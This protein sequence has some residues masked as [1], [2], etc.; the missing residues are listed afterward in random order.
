M[1]SSSS[2]SPE[3]QKL[4]DRLDVLKLKEKEL[5]EKGDMSLLGKLDDEISRIV[6]TLEEQHDVN[7]LELPCMQDVLDAVMEPVGMPSDE[8]Q[9][10]FSQNRK[11]P[12]PS[13]APM[14]IDYDDLGD[15]EEE[16]EADDVHVLGD[17]SF[18]P[19][20]PKDK[21][22]RVVKFY[23]DSGKQDM[24]RP[25][26]DGGKRVPVLQ[27]HQKDAI[28]HCRARFQNKQGSLVCHSMGLGKT[29]TALELLDDIAKGSESKLQTF[30]I[31]P[32]SLLKTWTNEFSKWHFPHVTMLEPCV[33]TASVATTV[34]TMQQ[35]DTKNMCIVPMTFDIFAATANDSC[36]ADIDID[37]MLIDEVHHLK[38][39]ATQKTSAVS[40][41]QEDRMY[42]G[43]KCIVIGLTGTPV[44]NSPL[45]MFTMINIVQPRAFGMIEQFKKLLSDPSKK[46]EDEKQLALHYN[47]IYTKASEIMHRQDASILEAQLPSK[48]EFTITFDGNLGESDSDPIMNPIQLQCKILNET[49][50][51]RVNLVLGLIHICKEQGHPVLVFSQRV[52]FL[53]DCKAEIDGLYLHGLNSNKAQDLVSQFQDSMAGHMVFYISTLVGCGITLTRAT[54]VIIADPSWNP[55]DDLQAL[56]RAYRFGQT[57]PVVVYRFV[58]GKSIEVRIKRQQAFKM[59]AAG[60]IIDDSRSL[61][62]FSNQERNEHDPDAQGTKESA[63][64]ITQCNDPV[65]AT[66]WR[67]NAKDIFHVVDSTKLIEC[68]AP[69]LRSDIFKAQQD[70]TRSLFYEANFHS[71]QQLTF[72]SPSQV[73]FPPIILSGVKHGTII[74]AFVQTRPYI[75]ACLQFRFCFGTEEEMKDPFDDSNRVW[76]PAVLPKTTL[77]DRTL[78]P[79]DVEGHDTADICII[80]QCRP[81]ASY[82]KDCAADNIPC[83]SSSSAVFKLKYLK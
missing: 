59:A 80:V 56:H 17:D 22:A 20:L 11:T 47:Y 51:E 71:T 60:Q 9:A 8:A 61:S 49:I 41:L 74:S 82:W 57:N 1:A 76:A 27:K 81:R 40:Q 62:L 45:D 50:H 15:S 24:T 23:S 55:M 31:C 12:R 30:L 73:C 66:F 67:D 7:V 37:L 39:G 70:Y 83:W 26:V 16:M 21:K 44:Q 25:Q 18:I 36:M 54:R 19:V 77:Q 52:K 43:R 46:L 64:D 2:F 69:L 32:K 5:E 75:P 42:F 6:E 53:E 4:V 78:I 35:M 68:G 34:S 14:P 58:C 13:C 3:T 10:Y 63:L 28:E 33:Q 48:H 38:N 79:I 72:S 29:L 65:L